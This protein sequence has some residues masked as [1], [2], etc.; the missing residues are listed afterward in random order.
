M[1]TASNHT[2]SIGM[3]AG[4]ICSLQYRIR[5]GGAAL[6]DI[7]KIEAARYRFEVKDAVPADDTVPS[8]E[9]IVSALGMA[10][11]RGAEHPAAVTR[12][13]VS[14][15]QLERITAVLT[16]VIGPMAKVISQAALEQAQSYDD[17]IDIITDKIPDRS[18]AA[19][20]RAAVSRRR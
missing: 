17:F 5:R 14:E 18:A 19:Q 7:R 3:A 13:T 9:A 1:T 4:R 6:E 8:T 11:S 10:L 16:E 20:F 12:D 2:A 15:A